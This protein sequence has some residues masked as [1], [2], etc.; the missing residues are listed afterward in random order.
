MFRLLGFGQTLSSAD[1]RFALAESKD[2]RNLLVVALN[3]SRCPSAK[4]GI[5]NRADVLLMF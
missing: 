4:V 1:C 3:Q 2:N 5:P